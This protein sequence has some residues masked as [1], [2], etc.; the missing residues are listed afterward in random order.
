MKDSGNALPF[1]VG[2][3]TSQHIASVTQNCYREEKWYAVN[4]LRA[5]INLVYLC[6]SSYR[7]A[8]ILCLGYKKLSVNVV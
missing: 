5:N 1:V 2:K 3:K 4:P 6:P 8:S 7:S